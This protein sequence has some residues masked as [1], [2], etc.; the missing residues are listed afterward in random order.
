MGMLSGL[1][2]QLD[3]DINPWYLIERYGRELIDRKVT[4]EL[5]WE[6]LRE[7]LQPF[8]ALPS[9]LDRLLTAVEEGRFTLQTSLERQ[10]MRRLDG[11]E[12][13][14][15]QLKWGI[16]AGAAWLSGTL[17]YVNGDAQ[18]GIASWVA[19]GLLSLWMLWGK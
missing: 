2:A 7:W 13:R 14:V 1:A 9:R 16:L 4:S 11:L 19:A 17:F 5:S 8:L 12:Q 3:P 10:T 6:L 15:G 18:L